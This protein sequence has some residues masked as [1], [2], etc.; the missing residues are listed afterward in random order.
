[1]DDLE[2]RGDGKKMYSTPEQRHLSR[3]N[4][5]EEMLNEIYDTPLLDEKYF[6]A[7][8]WTSEPD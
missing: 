1:M 8:P 7:H 5:H 4:I 2:K 6:K 3:T